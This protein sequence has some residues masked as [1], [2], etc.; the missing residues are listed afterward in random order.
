MRYYEECNKSA[1][2]KAKEAILSK[3]EK[4]KTIILTTNLIGELVIISK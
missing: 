1:P 3:N 4:L 2:T